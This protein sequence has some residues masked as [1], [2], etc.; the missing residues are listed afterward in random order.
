MHTRCSH[1][2]QLIQLAML[3]IHRLYSLYESLCCI[4]YISVGSK[5]PCDDYL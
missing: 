3:Y 4:M 2:L 1:L 5:I